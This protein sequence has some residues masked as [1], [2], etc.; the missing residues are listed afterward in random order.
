MIYLK[1]LLSFKKP[2]KT[3]RRDQNFKFI[4]NSFKNM[5]FLFSHTTSRGAR[6]FVLKTIDFYQTFISKDQGIFK[7]RTRSCRFFPSCS[8]YAA[9]AFRKYGFLKAFF[10]S[11]KRIIRCNPFQKGGFNPI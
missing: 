1:K 8:E 2:R 6:F 10:M 4:N 9:G 11:L 3:M 7:T 5:I